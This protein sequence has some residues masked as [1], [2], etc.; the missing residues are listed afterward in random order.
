MAAAVAVDGA[1]VAAVDSKRP[2]LPP[3]ARDPWRNEEL[4]ALGS[5]RWEAARPALGSWILTS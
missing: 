2:P 3:P 5:R 4:L 1:A